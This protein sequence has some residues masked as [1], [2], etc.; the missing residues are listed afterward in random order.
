MVQVNPDIHA[1]GYVFV[2]SN[3]VT[4]VFGGRADVL[5][6]LQDLRALGFDD[7]HLE[8]FIGEK[9][10]ETLDLSADHHGINA[11]LVRNMEAVMILAAGDSHRRADDA[12]RDGAAMVAVLM[13]GRED[14]RDE[15]VEILRR[16]HG[17][18]IRHWGRWTIE[19]FD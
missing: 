19:A 6:A 2:P 16:H 17:W 14:R 12:L 8:V 3:R 9:G 10:A 13:D 5:H 11:K 18:L 7:S 1:Y 4:A 15:V